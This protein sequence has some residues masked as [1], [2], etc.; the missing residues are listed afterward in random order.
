MASSSG[1]SSGGSSGGGSS[2]SSSSS[3]RKHPN[4]ASWL[5]TFKSPSPG[6]T[7]GH[8]G[9]QELQ[10]AA[11]TAVLEATGSV[12][13]SN[14]MAERRSAMTLR[15]ATKDTSTWLEHHRT[16]AEAS[17]EAERDLRIPVFKLRH[18]AR[19]HAAFICPARRHDAKHGDSCASPAADCSGK[20]TDK[21]CSHF[22]ADKV[23]VPAF[24][25]CPG[26]CRG[27]VLAPSLCYPI[28]ASIC[29]REDEP[30]FAVVGCESCEGQIR[31]DSSGS[32][33]LCGKPCT[34]CIPVYL[35]AEL[36]GRE[37]ATV[38]AERCPPESEANGN[39][40]SAVSEPKSSTVEEEAIASGDKQAEDP[41]A[42]RVAR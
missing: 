36:P 10:Q 5:A 40:T 41:P 9:D 37:R 23:R 4:L 7:H 35:H 27:A 11:A 17:G 26:S 8:G 25:R 3:K 32:L 19:R 21:A 38:L 22:G 15:Q 30:I 12:D 20:C 42:K 1:S 16:P 31:S 24:Y 14:S 33:V 39:E 18:G 34:R 2:S 13:G 6:E 28:A 29:E